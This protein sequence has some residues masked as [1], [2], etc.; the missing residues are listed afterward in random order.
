VSDIH[1]LSGAYAV[2]ALDDAERAQFERHLAECPACTSEVA[3]LR[4]AAALLAETTTST[5]SAELRER[6]LS[7]ISNVRPLPPVAPTVDEPRGDATVT[8]LEPR[9]RRRVLT[10]LAAAAAVVAIGTGGI[11]SQLNDDGPKD[12]VAV[13]QAASD[14]QRFTVPV[15]DGGSATVYRSEKL[16]EAAIVT[17]G[18]PAA[19]EGHSYALWFQHDAAMVPAGVM[20][21][22]EDNR[23]VLSGD[24]ASAD[25]V[26]ITVEP[27]GAEPTQ[28]SEDVVALFSFDA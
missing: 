18:M 24:A 9:R 26:G 28:P 20:P 1:A 6:V 17:Q 15:G 5:P 2:D 3:S 4:E 12:R 25:G 27:A 11:V 22:G 23:V 21:T 13:I 10:F 14:V 19:P 8:P 16:N 7:G